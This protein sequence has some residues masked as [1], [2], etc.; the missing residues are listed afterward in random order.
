MIGAAWWVLVAAFL[1]AGVWLQQ[2]P[3]FLFGLLLALGTLA[4]AL[5][6]RQCLTGVGYRRS[7]SAAR[8][9]FGEETELTVE[10]VNAKLLPLA[11]LRV[12]DEWPVELP[13]LTGR[14]GNSHKADRLLLDNSLALRWYERVRRTYRLR[15]VE[16]GAFEFGPAALYSGD[17]FGVQ[18]RESTVP[19]TDILLVHPKVT[20]VWDWRLPSGRPL[21]EVL[22]TRRLV[23][24]PLRFAGV[25][26]YAP[27]DNPR[28]IHWKNSARWR[29][30]QTRVFDPE[31][32]QALVLLVDVRT[33]PRGTFRIVPA[34]LEL[35]ISAAASIASHA[36]GERQ[37]VGLYSN[38]N[39]AG[40]AGLLEVPISRDLGQ[41]TRVLD[42][43]AR[44][45]GISLLPCA[46]LLSR[47]ARRLPWGASLV[48]ISSQPDEDL[49]AAIWSAQ[50]AG[51]S[52]LLLTIGEAPLEA[53]A[54]LSVQH[55]GGVDAW[56]H[57]A[58][59]E[60]G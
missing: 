3:L 31:A 29:R 19:A 4:S 40:R 27:G 16:R 32:N 41:R 52:A 25:R 2:G 8:V 13:L 59:L 56:N 48:V 35:G 23:V 42:V 60:P 51:H 57:L 53:P 24:D 1:A 5:W 38:A 20:P 55:L 58:A 7:L 33:S 49:L 36:L 37:A 14:L 54:G 12:R 9:S 11:W 47:L 50:T 21:G 17:I 43:C 45:T 6:A 15:G 44:L 30:L 26:D 39:G 28:H 34:Y 10:I 46:D 22:A 18:V